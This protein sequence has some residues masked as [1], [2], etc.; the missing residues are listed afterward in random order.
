MTQTE[1]TQTEKTRVDEQK[2]IQQLQAEI[3][4]LREN[5][6]EPEDIAQ[7]VQQLNIEI[8]KNITMAPTP[9]SGGGTKKVSKKDGE[10]DD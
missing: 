9:E 10:S 6:A 8:Q 3:K 2:R 1:M 4:E 7:L 5:G